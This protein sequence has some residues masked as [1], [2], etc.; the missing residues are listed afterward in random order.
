MQTQPPTLTAKGLK[1]QSIGPVDLAVAA[2]GCLALVGPSGAGKSLTLKMIAD[3]VPHDGDCFIDGTA[4]SSM[5]APRWRSQVRYVSSEPGWWAPSVA[6][7]FAD[8]KTQA[9]AMKRLFLDASLLSAAPDRLSTGER[10]RMAF[11]RAIEDRPKVLLLDEPTSALDP[12]SVTAVEEIVRELMAAG[13]AIVLTSH[14]PEQVER[15]ADE[16][17]TLKKA[18]EMAP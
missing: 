3:L 7:H 2:G 18:T 17:L 13:A 1:F 16:V 9:D 4:A 6:G 15:L 12:A 5:P 8:P 14:D 10:Q 11:L